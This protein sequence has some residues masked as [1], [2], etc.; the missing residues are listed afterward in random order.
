MEAFRQEL[1]LAAASTVDRPTARSMTHANTAPFIADLCTSADQSSASA[2]PGNS[3]SRE[4]ATTPLGGQE[5]EWRA[6][7]WLL[8]LSPAQGHGQSTPGW[9]AT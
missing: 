2:Q 8:P 1:A 7:A 3:P 6:N 9:G 5:P 4:N